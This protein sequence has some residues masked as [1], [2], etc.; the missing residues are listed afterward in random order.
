MVVLAFAV[1]LFLRRVVLMEVFNIWHFFS[2]GFWAAERE[3]IVT[4]K[5]VKYKQILKGR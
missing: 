1:M 3:T 2:V 4:K 5:V